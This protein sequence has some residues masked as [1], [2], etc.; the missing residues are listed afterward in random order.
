MISTVN[1]WTEQIKKQLECSLGSQRGGEGQKPLGTNRKVLDCIL[2]DGEGFLKEVTSKH[3]HDE[4]EDTVLAE[5]S[6]YPKL[7]VPRKCRESHHRV[8][9]SLLKVSHRSHT[10][11]HCTLLG[12]QW[13]SQAFLSL[14]FTCLF[15]ELVSLGI[16]QRTIKFSHC[17]HVHDL[18]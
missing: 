14:W 8:S 15:S 2:V 7:P 3:Q 12:A 9:S 10:L 16:L 17:E 11:L 4:S 13:V 18:P 6:V 5:E 1:W